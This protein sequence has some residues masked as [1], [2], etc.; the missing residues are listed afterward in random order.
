MSDRHLEPAK[1]VIA[2]VGGVDK[3]AAITGKHVSRIYR[4]MYGKERGGTGGFVPH[5]DAVKLL[6]AAASESLP[7]AP[8]DFFAI[9]GSVDA[10]A[11]EAA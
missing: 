7:L 1:T 2:R 6:E 8:A 10:S 9:G 5:E 11:V 3:A 4:W